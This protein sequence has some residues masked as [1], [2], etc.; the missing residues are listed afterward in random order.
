MSMYMTDTFLLIYE[1]FHF[2]ELL[3]FVRVRQNNAAKYRQISKIK[4]ICQSHI[5]I[6]FLFCSPVTT[7]WFCWS[8]ISTLQSGSMCTVLAT[9]HDGE[10]SSEHEDQRPDSQDRTE[11]PTVQ[12]AFGDSLASLGVTLR[13]WTIREK[14]EWKMS[15]KRKQI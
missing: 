13:E 6:F 7:L 4:S 11:R 9:Y 5:S 8:Q 3:P 14:K 12:D 1:K 15:E 2:Q 10:G